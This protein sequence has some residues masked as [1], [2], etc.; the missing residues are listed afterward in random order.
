MRCDVKN[1]SL[2]VLTTMI[3]ASAIMTVSQQSPLAFG[4]TQDLKKPDFPPFVS[5]SEPQSELLPAWATKPKSRIHA[6]L[7]TVYEPDFPGVPLDV[8]LTTLGDELRIP[9]HIEQHELDLLGVDA[10]S[11]VT[12]Q[13][14]YP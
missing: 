8:V 1:L 5:K 3:L 7:G 10:D 13:L 9:V 14:P 4:Q 12:L 6:A 2:V 11:P